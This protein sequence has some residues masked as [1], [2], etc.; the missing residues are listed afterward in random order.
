MGKFSDQVNKLARK[1]EERLKAIAREAAQETASI[2]QR[3]RGEGGRLPVVTGFLHA[4]IQASMDT[5]P[6]GPTTNE[7]THGGKKKYPIGSQ[8][9]GEPVSV[10]LLRWNPNDGRK[11]F[12][13]WTAIYARHMEA[14]YGFMRG[15]VEKWDQT[16]RKAVRKVE[17]GFG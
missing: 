11:I 13:G 15:A 10:A 3:T 16:V 5:M 4:S 8:A 6:S 9:A 1:Y 2:A 7:G 12:I 14:K 17:S